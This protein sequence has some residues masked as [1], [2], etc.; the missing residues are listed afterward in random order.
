MVTLRHTRI[1]SWQTRITVQQAESSSVVQ[2]VLKSLAPEWENKK[3]KMQG[4]HFFFFFLLCCFVNVR[5]CQAQIQAHCLRF[6]LLCFKIKCTDKNNQIKSTTLSRS[7]NPNSLQLKERTLSSE[8]PP[9]PPSPRSASLLS[10]AHAYRRRRGFICLAQHFPS[11]PLQAR[12]S[13]SPGRRRRMFSGCFLWVCLSVQQ[14]QREQRWR[15]WR[16][17]WVLR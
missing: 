9:P 7:P 15:I 1:K 3:A 16:P 5:S 14:Q 11:S 6:A 17:A 8:L 4:M 10:N 13:S 2:I 12:W